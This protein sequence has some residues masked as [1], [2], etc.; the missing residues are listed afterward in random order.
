LVLALW[1]D[2]FL[3][4]CC[5]LVSVYC[6]AKFVAKTIRD[7]MDANKY[8]NIETTNRM[9]SIA[10]IYRTNAQSR[11]LEEACVKNNLPYVIFGSAVS[12]YK[13]REI[14]DCLCF[15][16]W[17]YNGRDRSAMLRAMKT[18]TRGIGDVAQEEFEQYCSL[19]ADSCNLANKPTPLDVLL[20][21]SDDPSGVAACI[22]VPPSTECI[23][24]RALKP[25]MLLSQQMRAIRDLAYQ[26]PVEIVLAYVI[27]TLNLLP[28]IGKYSESK[29]EFEERKGNVQEL[30]QASKRYTN[31]G[32]CLTLPDTGDGKNQRD[33]DDVGMNVELAT[34]P[35]GTFLDDISL[36]T[37]TAD[38]LQKGNDQRSVVV[39]LMTIHAS[40]GMEF[41]EVFL[42]GNEDGIFPTSQA[43]KEGE[44][45]VALEE[46]KRLCY[47]AMTRAKTELC[48]TWRREVPIFTSIGMVTKSFDRSRFLDVLASKTAK[49]PESPVSSS[50]SPPSSPPKQAQPRDYSSSAWSSQSAA[51]DFQGTN[52][53]YAINRNPTTTSSSRPLQT[54]SYSPQQPWQ[55]KGSRAQKSPI[56]SNV[57][58][59]PSW[60]G[61]KHNINKGSELP[62][63]AVGPQSSPSSSLPIKNK[64][65]SRGGNSSSSTSATSNTSPPA[66][67]STWFF[68]VGSAVMH[69]KLGRGIVLQPPPGTNSAATNSRDDNNNN[70]VD[71]LVRVKFPESGVEHHFSARGSEITPILF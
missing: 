28:H 52:S 40:K 55:N 56:S 27:D 59:Q 12:F 39:C 20:S 33:D 7:A 34:S 54:K 44:G 63:K 62:T 26:Q 10:L 30:Q 67:D 41:D 15:L 14:L 42:V 3:P 70:N 46:E 61:N 69:K 47:V 16:R 57:R 49:K 64:K 65:K 17:I 2:A 25:L 43:I 50:W 60:R 66:P 29:S 21:L 11:A 53:V 48:L 32:P 1:T 36:V 8:G 24:G 13:R 6:I 31:Q 68:P 58:Q 22:G 38:E 51:T 23:S 9:S 71:L 5:L 37:E 4:C 35:L 45:S 19:V 18:P